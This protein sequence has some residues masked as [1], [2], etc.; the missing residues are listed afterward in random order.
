MH[1]LLTITAVPP[2]VHHIPASIA[3]LLGALAVLLTLWNAARIRSFQRDY[4][5]QGGFPGKPYEC[6]LR[7]ADSE[8]PVRCFVGATDSALYLIADPQPPPRP[9]WGWGKYGS[10]R[11]VFKTDLRIPW[12]SLQCRAGRM[13]LKEVIWFENR[14]RK[15]FVYVPREIGERVLR[16]AGRQIPV[17]N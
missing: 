8:W 12:T 4:G 13:F 17:R 15:F 11:T 2:T 5:Y 6:D 16:D 1:T 9:W 10:F 7:S 14:P 3:L